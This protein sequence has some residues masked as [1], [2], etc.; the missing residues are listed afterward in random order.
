MCTE[1][2]PGIKVS[3]EKGQLS[4]VADASDFGCADESLSVDYEDES[5]KIGFNHSYISELLTIFLP[6]IK[7]KIAMVALLVLV[8]KMNLLQ[9]SLKGLMTMQR[10]MF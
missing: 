9:C 1:R 10:F 6:T 5:L 8:L 3:V 2:A 7:N 4:L